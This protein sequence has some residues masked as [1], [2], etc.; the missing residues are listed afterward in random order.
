M[1]N[2]ADGDGADGGA[3]SRQWGE[4]LGAFYEAAAVCPL[5]GPEGQPVTPEAVLERTDLLALTTGSGQVIYPAFQFRGRRLV[6][7]LDRVLAELPE[8]VVSRWTLSS[9]L[10]SPERDLG[11]DRPIDVLFDQGP[12]GVDAVVHAARAWAAQ[13]EG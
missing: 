9:W 7:G 10:V 2:V 11:G 1:T 13:L 3:P 6:P 8:S 12:A 5:L 4:H